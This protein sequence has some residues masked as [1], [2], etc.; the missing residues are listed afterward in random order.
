MTIRALVVDDE[1]R[2]RARLL[3][4]LAPHTDISVIG[5][6]A[7]GTQAVSMVLSL[8][9]DLVFFDVQMPELSGT[10]AVAQIRD[11]LPQRVRPAVV[12]TTAFAQHAV[13]AF[14]LEGT[15]YLL[16][17]IERD[18]LAEAL[19]RVRQDRWATGEQAPPPPTPAPEQFITGLRGRAIE[20]IAVSTLVLVQVDEGTAWAY[21]TDSRRTRLARGLSE[22]EAALES[23]PFVRVSRSAI[24]NS[25][26]VQRI[27]PVGSSFEAEME[28]G[29]R[30][31]VS[32]RRVKRLQ[33]A[34]GL[35]S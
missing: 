17:P 15:D 11:Y 32:R 24:V 6:A 23:P 27:H 4:L 28:G 30:V 19:R 25:A 2:A 26:R 22:V 5:E 8:R 3:R 29:H 33:T 18:R 20:S 10:D 34:V 1:P 7:T 13:Q 12:F 9:P 16:K 21:T 31:S 14:A 35:T